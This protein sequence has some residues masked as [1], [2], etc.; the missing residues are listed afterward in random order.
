MAN[1]ILRLIER[2]LDMS[3]VSSL[4]ILVGMLL[5]SAN[6]LG[7]TFEI[8]SIISSFVQ[9]EMKNKPWLSDSKFEKKFY[10]KMAPLTE[11]LKVFAIVVRSVT[12]WFSR[13]IIFGESFVVFWREIMNLIPFQ[14]FFMLLILSLKYL[15]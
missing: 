11:L 1:D 15:P 10:M 14:V 12:V 7:F 9:G 5:V 2:C 6:F 4:R 3:H 8:I 13:L